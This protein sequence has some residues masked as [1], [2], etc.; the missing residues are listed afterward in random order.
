AYS[1]YATGGGSVEP[2]AN[3]T[4]VLALQSSSTSL[5]VSLSPTW[6]DTISIVPPGGTGGG[7]G[8]VTLTI[9]D[10]LGTRTVYSGQTPSSPLVL[11]L[12]AGT[13]L[14]RATAT[15]TYGGVPTNASALSTVTILNGNVGTVLAL[16]YATTTAVAGTL[17]GPSSATV[18][19]G[20]SASFSFSVRNTGNLP[21][22]VHPVGTPS[23]WNFTFSF[24]N[25]T[26]LPGPSGATFSGEVRVGVP[27]GTDV[28]HPGMTMSSRPRAEWWSGRCAL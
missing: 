15:G 12:P 24:A 7:I 14:V 25:V 2:L 10:A 13:Y 19:A 9:T 3:L 8:P 20:G 27:A 6:V 21:V 17:L 4:S 5:S 26:L 1:L 28:L 16:A 11:A 22:T 18:A 23:Y